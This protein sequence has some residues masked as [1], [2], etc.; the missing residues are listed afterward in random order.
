MI[1][2]LEIEWKGKDAVVME[3]D[4]I[5]DR[6][7]ALSILKIDSFEGGLETFCKFGWKG[8]TRYCNREQAKEMSLTL[9]DGL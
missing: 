5:P 3:W 4:C 9:R 1:S 8:V 6:V 7:D 2:G